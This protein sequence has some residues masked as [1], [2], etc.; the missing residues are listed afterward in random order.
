M[1]TKTL[2]THAL[3]LTTALTSLLATPALAQEGT[4][5]AEARMDTINVI[6]MRAQMQSA[7]N[8]QRNSDTVESV[9]TRDDIGQFPDQNVAESVRKITGVNVLNDQG[10][11]RFVSV[12]G[13]DPEL[14]ASSLNGIRLP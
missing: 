7:I 4:Q 1:K 13:L 11:G 5:M 10:E 2:R 8:Q 12:R 9:V 3:L 6:G 14:N